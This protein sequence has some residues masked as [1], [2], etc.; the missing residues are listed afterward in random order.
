MWYICIYILYIYLDMLGQRLLL[1]SSSMLQQFAASASSVAGRS[2]SPDNRGVQKGT[3][4]PHQCGMISWERDEIDWNWWDSKNYP[5][6]QS[7]SG[8]H[9][10]KKKMGSIAEHHWNLSLRRQLPFVAM[11]WNL[12]RHRSPHSHRFVRSCMTCIW[13][14]DPKIRWRCSWCSC[15]HY[16]RFR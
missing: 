10:H 16:L 12:S 3:P 4:K 5:N 1:F 9:N 7:G 14:C 2:S 6:Q 13:K 11:G 15:F 8:N